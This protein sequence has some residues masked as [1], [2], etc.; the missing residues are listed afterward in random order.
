MTK[1]VTPAEARAA[2]EQA[3]G[4]YQPEPRLVPAAEAEPREDLGA[5]DYYRAA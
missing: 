3:Y 4:Y 1:T 2:L 5:P